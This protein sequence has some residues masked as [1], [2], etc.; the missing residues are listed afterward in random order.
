M[1]FIDDLTYPEIAAVM[2]KSEGAIRVI[3]HR[4]LVKLKTIL[5]KAQL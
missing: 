3:Q 5:E 4:G 2:G 1:R